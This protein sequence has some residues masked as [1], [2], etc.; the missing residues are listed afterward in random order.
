MSWPALP[1]FG[2]VENP[3]II[4]PFASNNSPGGSSPP[5]IHGNL[6]LLSTGSD[7]LLSDGGF[8]LLS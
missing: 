8:F 5:P 6:F 2:I 3:L 7:F 1:A 4:S